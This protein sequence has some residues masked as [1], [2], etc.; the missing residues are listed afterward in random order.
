M[1]GKHLT[2]HERFYIEK[3]NAEGVNQSCI[4]RELGVPPST[5]SRELR[6]NT[7]PAFN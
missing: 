7:D 3:R 6:R 2:Q 5:L 1:K 4:A